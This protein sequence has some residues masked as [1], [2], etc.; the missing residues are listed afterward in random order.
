MDRELGVGVMEGETL[1]MSP[2]FDL[3]GWVDGGSVY[4]DGED[5]GRLGETGLSALPKSEQMS[6]FYL[7]HAFCLIY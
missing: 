1:R 5:W 4:W 2:R 6:L 7:F 3:Q